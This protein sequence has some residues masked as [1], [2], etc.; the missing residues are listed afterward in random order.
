MSDYIP[1]L[2]DA[3]SNNEISEPNSVNAHGT[4]SAN[5]NTETNVIT[6]TVP[7]SMTLN[8]DSVEV[9]GNYF[10]EWFVR[11]NGTQKG[12]TNL[13]CAERSKN[14]RYEDAPITANAGD[15]VTVSIQHQFMGSVQFQANL[16]GRLS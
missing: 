9:W 4:A 5:F 13:S 7:V 1:N 15:T 3:G 10:G 8:I 12:G 16:M 2:A 6:Y 14:L 11:V